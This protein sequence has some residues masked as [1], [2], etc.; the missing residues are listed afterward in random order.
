MEARRT[1]STFLPAL[2]RVRNR[3][4]TFRRANAFSRDETLIG[5]ACRYS[6]TEENAKTSNPAPGVGGT[7]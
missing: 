6:K 4:F 2:S 5:F 3:V 7:S 1:P